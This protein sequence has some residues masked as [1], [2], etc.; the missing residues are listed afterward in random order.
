MHEQIM[1]CISPFYRDQP[2]LKKGLICGLKS[3]MNLPNLLEKGSRWHGFDN[4]PF[5]TPDTHA[6]W[7]NVDTPEQKT[8]TSYENEGEVNAIKKVLKALSKS[9]G[10]ANYYN[11][12]AKEEDKEIAVITYYLLQMQKIQKTLF[13]SFSYR[14]WLSFEA[15]KYENDF[16][17]PL[18]INTVD[19]FQGMERNIVIV[20]T[21]RSDKQIDETGVCK[22]NYHYPLE[23][24]TCFL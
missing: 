12:M 15:Y 8:G 23:S 18:R 6:I 1:N 21:V 7:V 5:I 3:Q 2:E 16:K 22:S 11:A 24:A 4:P 9:D 10:F 14:Q 17:I 20:S 19:K 13:P